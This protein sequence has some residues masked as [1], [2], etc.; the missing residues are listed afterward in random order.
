L[1][2]TLDAKRKCDLVDH[3]PYA[4]HALRSAEAAEGAVCVFIR[5][6]W[7]SALCSA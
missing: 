7:M 6:E 1:D 3:A 5:R 4:E 2:Y